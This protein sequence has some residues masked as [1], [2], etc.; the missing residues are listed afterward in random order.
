MMARSGRFKISRKVSLPGWADLPP[1]SGPAP[2]RI[3]RLTVMPSR[4]HPGLWVPE[5]SQGINYVANLLR[6]LGDDLVD[7]SFS[8]ERLVT[9]CQECGIEVLFLP[10]S[11]E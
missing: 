7:G 4:H 6:V 8:S 1:G 10:C 11:L 5:S 2:P 3:K 9:V